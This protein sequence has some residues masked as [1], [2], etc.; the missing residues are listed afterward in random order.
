MILNDYLPLAQRRLNVGYIPVTC[1]LACPVTDYITRHSNSKDALVPRLFQ[2]FAETKEALIAGSIQAGFLVAPMA[3]AL[4][5]ARGADSHR[6][7][8]PPL[9]KLGGG[10]KDGPVRTIADLAGRKVAIPNRFSDERLL[11]IRALTLNHIDWRKVQMLEMNPPDCTGR[12]GHG[13]D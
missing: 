6:L 5:I 3:L 10:Q 8:R 2:G 13:R 4:L 1:H 12:P 7:P 9:R 11:L